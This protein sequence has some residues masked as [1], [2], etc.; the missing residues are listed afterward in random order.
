VLCTY[1]S[2]DGKVKD[3]SSAGKFRRDFRQVTAAAGTEGRDVVFCFIGAG[4]HFQC[5][6]LVSRLTAG[7]AIGLLTEALVL[8][9]AV[10]IFGRGDRTVAAVFGITVPGKFLFE[11][12]HPS[13]QKPDPLHELEVNVYELL[14]L[15]VPMVQGL[16][17]MF[18][19]YGNLIK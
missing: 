8:F 6:A 18:V 1:R 15:F 10:F 17:G 12:S 11:F 2:D 13:L 5:M 4:C 7:F 19:E 3:L 14:N 16:S 9:G